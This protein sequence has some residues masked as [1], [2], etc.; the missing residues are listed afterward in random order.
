MRDQPGLAGV[1]VDTLYLDTTYALPRHRLPPQTEAIA[2]MV[3][4]RAGRG[5]AVAVVRSVPGSKSLLSRR[6]ERA[7]HGTYGMWKGKCVW[8]R[9][10]ISE[11]RHLAVVAVT[12]PCPAPA[13][14]CAISFPVEGLAIL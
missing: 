5:G 7:M 10:R 3:Q 4:V 6:V 12:G 1:R 2:M 14:C 11:S 8:V 13:T 9:G